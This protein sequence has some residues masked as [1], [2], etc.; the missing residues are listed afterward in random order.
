[1]GPT[2]DALDGTT[3]ARMSL[4]TA[5]AVRK[6]HRMSFA[7]SL[8][9]ALRTFF[10]KLTMLAPAGSL[11]NKALVTNLERATKL[12]T[13]PQLF[14]SRRIGVVAGRD[15]IRNTQEEN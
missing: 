15:A 6:E 5:K 13:S 9:H 1:M 4:F 14:Y 11:H 8:R 7:P 12:V 3:L 10:V 2:L